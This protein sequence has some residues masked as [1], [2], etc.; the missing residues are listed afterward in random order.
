MAEAPTELDDILDD[1]LA[2]F[3]DEEEEETSQAMP[4]SAVKTSTSTTSTAQPTAS[5]TE[6]KAKK[7]ESKDRKDNPGGENLVGKIEELLGTISGKETTVEDLSKLEKALSEEL[8]KAGGEPFTKE[9]K[10]MADEALASQNGTGAKKT[11]INGIDDALKQLS[12]SR[13]NMPKSEEEALKTLMAELQ[14]LDI[15]GDG[16]END[17]LQAL[18]SEMKSDVKLGEG[19]EGG[20]T[21]SMDTFVDQM[22]A[23]M[24]SKEY[25]YPAVKEISEK[26]PEFLKKK[27]GKI[28]ETK[29]KQYQ[30]QF[31]CFQQLCDMFENDS[32]NSSGNLKVVELMKKMQSYGPPPKEIMTGLL[33]GMPFDNDGHPQLDDFD[34][35]KFGMNGEECSVM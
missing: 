25:L 14:N 21:A 12:E 22:I 20:N 1:A 5:G 32:G 34:P 31:K 7:Q 26:F 4:V 29:M 27:E 15:G 13:K 16:S 3:D 24:M 33:P 30:E 19:S 23:K 28:S 35:S 18:F 11:E 9:L 10:K 6:K 8:K 17:P 2:E